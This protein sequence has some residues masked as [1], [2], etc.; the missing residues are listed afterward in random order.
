MKFFGAG[1][2]QM[3]ALAGDAKSYAE[4]LF[5]Y[6]SIG[7]L[8]VESAKKVLVD[9]AQRFNVRYE[10]GAL[11]H[12]VERTE[13]YPFFLQVWGYHVWR[14]AEKSPINRED[15]LVATQ[16]AIDELDRGFFNIRLDRLT[17]RQQNYARAMAALDPGPLTS[18]EVANALGLTVN[19]AAPIRNEII[20]KGMAYSPK[21][22]RIAFTVPLFHEFMQRT[23][24]M[25]AAK[26]PG[27]AGRGGKEVRRPNFRQKA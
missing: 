10:L 16:N 11:D 6:L 18:T 7:Q 25:S 8:D 1:L 3:A 5:D 9:P 19:A 23:I 15:A 26:K 20:K 4:R 12:I 2:P 27:E 24:P 17:E 22:G 14:V 13:G 21:R